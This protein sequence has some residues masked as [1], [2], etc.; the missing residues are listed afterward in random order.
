M[1]TLLRKIYA[2]VAFDIMFALAAVF[3]AT[4]AIVSIGTGL[5][6]IAPA[7]D[8]L[9]KLLSFF[10]LIAAG[11]VVS[12][13]STRLDH[14]LADDFVYH[15]LTK[16]AFIAIFGFIF[17]AVFWEVLVADTLGGI[18]GYGMVTVI[19]LCWSL[20]WFYSRWRGTGA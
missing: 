16:S 10:G 9:A 7:T 13:G 8:P 4:A 18:P 15:L 2:P 5:P 17:F 20:S 12:I 11:V 1:K 6:A 3:F 14:K 19:M